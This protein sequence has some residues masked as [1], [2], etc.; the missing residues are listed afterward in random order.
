MFAQ[1]LNDLFTDPNLGTEAIWRAGGIDP[2]TPVRVIVR[3]PDRI[4]EFGEVRVAAAT[5]A[6]ELR[7]AEVAILMEGDTLEFGGAVYV[8][9][10]EPM[11]DAARLVWA[12]EARPA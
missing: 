2:G 8:V 5:M 1:A 12:A 6:L 4:A 9:Q 3:R 10:G 7:I 11:R